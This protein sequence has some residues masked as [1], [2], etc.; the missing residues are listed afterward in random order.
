[1]SL[2]AEPVTMPEKPSIAARQCVISA[3][4]YFSCVAV[5]PGLQ[6]YQPMP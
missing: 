5:S 3:S 2:R 6:N 4:L 1:M